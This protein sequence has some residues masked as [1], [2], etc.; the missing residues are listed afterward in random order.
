M[1]ALANGTPVVGFITPVP[2]NL[3]STASI[4]N[5]KFKGFV[6]GVCQPPV[7]V[8]ERT[9]VRSMFSNPTEPAVCGNI[10]MVDV[11]AL[12]IVNACNFSVPLNKILLLPS[13]TEFV[14]VNAF[15]LLL[16]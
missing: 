14:P 3:P 15:V 9:L 2:N 4:C 7:N 11:G 13:A 16:P 5:S 10:N 6:G 8:T 1:L 12:Y